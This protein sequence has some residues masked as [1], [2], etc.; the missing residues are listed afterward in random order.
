MARF[1]VGYFFVSGFNGIAEKLANIKELKLLIG[2]VTN[3]ETLE[4]L[5]EGYQR[6]ELVSENVEAQKYPKRTDIKKMAALAADRVRTSMELMDQ[7]DEGQNLVSGLM[8]FIEEKRMK[9]R[10]YTK[11]R[12]HAKAYIFDYG[13]V[14]DQSGQQL[15]R[16]ES[17]IAIVGSSN[18]TLAGISHNTELN[19]VV[20]GTDNL[21]SLCD[22][23]KNFGMNPRILMNC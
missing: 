3:R 13:N 16:H 4:Q 5:A 6:L 23:L 1:A 10:I 14:F 11:G 12:L 18:L 8:R 9:V 2:N 19:V 15:D 21:P 22:G 7:T 17:G 20:Q